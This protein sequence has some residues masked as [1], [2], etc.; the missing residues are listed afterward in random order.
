MSRLLAPRFVIG[1]LLLVAVLLAAMLAPLLA[2]YN[3]GDQDLL[4][5]AKPK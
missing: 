5:D 1:M 4:G 2:P 3:P